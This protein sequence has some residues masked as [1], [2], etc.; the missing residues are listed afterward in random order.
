[1]IISQISGALQADRMAT[2]PHAGGG[3]RRWRWP[4]PPPTG[5]HIH[6]TSHTPT[7]A[8]SQRVRFNCV[9]GNIC[10]RWLAALS[11][12]GNVQSGDEPHPGTPVNP[13]SEINSRARCAREVSVHAKIWVTKKKKEKCWETFLMLSYNSTSGGGGHI[14]VRWPKERVEIRGRGEGV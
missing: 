6:L 12:G 1:M 3:G 8:R 10:I 7:S 11:E 13:R 5:T 9:Q 14:C 4:P 2:F